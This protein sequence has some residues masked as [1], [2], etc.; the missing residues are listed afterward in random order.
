MDLLNIDRGLR[1]HL[2]GNNHLAGGHQR[3]TSYPRIGILREQ[4]IKNGI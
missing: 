1:G 2:T 3:F 4:C